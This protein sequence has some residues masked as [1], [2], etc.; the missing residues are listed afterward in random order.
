MDSPDRHG[1]RRRGDLSH[2]PLVHC[3]L[4]LPLALPVQYPLTV[5]LIF[6]VAIPCSWLAV[7]RKQATRQSET[8]A[9]IEK[10]GG[11]VNWSDPSGPAWLRSLL[12]DDF[13]RSVTG[14][15]PILPTI[16]PVLR[17]RQHHSPQVAGDR[18]SDRSHSNTGSLLETT[19]IGLCGKREACKVYLHWDTLKKILAHE[20][21]PW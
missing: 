11:I 18:V 20:E 17:C 14:S 8:P 10:L 2:V 7:E 15:T 16:H 9:A 19:D 6:V 3:Q 1:E 13:F 5:F 12:G 21:P 4:A